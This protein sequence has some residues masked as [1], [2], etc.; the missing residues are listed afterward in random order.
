MTQFPALRPTSRQFVPGTVPI[1]TFKS[2]AGKETRVITGSSPVDHVLTFTFENVSE[3]VGKQILDHWYLQ[4]G[5]ALGFTLPSA[6]W[7]GWAEYSAAVASDQKWRYSA[8][9][10]V[11]TI[12]PGIMVL[13]VQLLSLL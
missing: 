6:V 3:A 2:I 12:S 1:S 7:A 9:P 11:N 4:Q 5:M 13:N 8:A 10:S